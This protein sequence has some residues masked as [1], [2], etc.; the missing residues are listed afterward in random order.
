MPTLEKFDPNFGEF[1]NLIVISGKAKSGKT[2]LVAHLSQKINYDNIIIVSNN[3]WYISLFPGAKFYTE[4]EH[5]IIFELFDSQTP[6][7]IP[8]LFIVDESYSDCKDDPVF[9]SLLQLY[10]SYRINVILVMPELD[11]SRDKIDYLFY[12]KSDGNELLLNYPDLF[13]S[14][15]HYQK[16]VKRYNKEFRSIVVDDNKLFWYNTK[17]KKEGWKKYLYKN[18]LGYII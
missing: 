7:P 5:Q 1:A 2:T 12:L 15:E 4:F 13:K 11:I 14:K 18:T 16:I 10:K 8:Y 6:K 17:K 3:Q 9:K